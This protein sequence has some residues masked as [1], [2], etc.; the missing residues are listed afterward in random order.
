MIT[1]IFHFDIEF[2]YLITQ[3]VIDWEALEKVLDKQNI[4]TK[5]GTINMNKMGGNYR[6]KLYSFTK[7]DYLKFD[8]KLIVDTLTEKY[9]FTF[10][11]AP[12]YVDS[13]RRTNKPSISVTNN[14]IFPVYTLDYEGD[15]IIRVSNYEI[16]LVGRLPTD[17]CYQNKLIHNTTAEDAFEKINSF[18]FEVEPNLATAAQRNRL[19]DEVCNDDKPIMEQNL[20]GETI[21]KKAYQEGVEAGY[22]LNVPDWE[23]LNNGQGYMLPSDICPYDDLPLKVSWLAGFQAGEE[24]YEEENY[25]EE[26]E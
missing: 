4:K 25:E 23:H 19:I 3:P 14:E 21:D 15:L 22:N 8:A 17:L 12:E 18:L 10:K 7:P 16:Y 1:R 13:V 11:L 9:G 26:N 5:A 20:T 2:F 24:K 6:K